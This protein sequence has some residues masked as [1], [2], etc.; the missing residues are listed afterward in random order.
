MRKDFKRKLRFKVNGDR[1]RRSLNVAIFRL[2]KKDFRADR[3]QREI[4]MRLFEIMKNLQESFWPPLE[5]SLDHFLIT[6]PSHFIPQRFEIR[7]LALL[8][9]V[10]EQLLKKYS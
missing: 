9:Y 2:L 8:G 4:R 10:G 3:D 1:V 6:P 5:A 7:I